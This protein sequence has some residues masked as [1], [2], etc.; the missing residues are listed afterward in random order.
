M[1]VPRGRLGVRD[2]FRVR[3]AQGCE[4]VGPDER[5]GLQGTE[6]ILLCEDDDSIR[7]VTELFLRG[8]GYD[9]LSAGSGS[10]ALALSA[11]REG[12]I[13][14]LVTDV[15]MPDLNGRE[16]AARLTSK[17]PEMKTLYISGPVRRSRTQVSPRRS[18][19]QVKTS[20]AAE[21]QEQQVLAKP[22]H[23][24]QPTAHCGPAGQQSAI[25]SQ[26]GRARRTGAA[27]EHDAAAEPLPSDAFFSAKRGEVSEKESPALT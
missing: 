16:L 18:R 10:A 24:E 15:I 6:T 22:Q 21:P 4:P 12:R 17:R 7:Q 25:S 14:L 9:V 5:A 23:K 1:R 2:R 3:G 26:S 13:D 19:K 27:R 8:S 11:E 20:P